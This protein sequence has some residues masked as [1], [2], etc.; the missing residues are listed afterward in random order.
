VIL[1]VY[2]NPTDDITGVCI[3]VFSCFLFLGFLPASSSSFG[4]LFLFAQISLISQMRYACM[5]EVA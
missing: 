5:K 4:F 3:A 1:A 2:Y